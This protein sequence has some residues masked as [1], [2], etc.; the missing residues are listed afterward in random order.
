MW[1]TKEFSRLVN[2][3]VR[4]LHYYDKIDLLKPSIRE[5]NDYRLYSEDDL[6]KLQQIIALKF[7]GFELS[8]IKELLDNEQSIQQRFRAQADM[9]QQKAEAT[10]HAS[11]LLGRLVEEAEQNKSISWEQVLTMIEVFQMT[12][13][14]EHSWV[15]EIYNENELKQYAEF[16]TKLKSGKTAAEKKAFEENWYNLL[17]E[18]NQMLSTDPTSSAGKKMGEKFMQWVNDVYGKEYAHLRTKKFEKGFGEGK[19]LDDVGLTKE[20]VAWL[21]K[22][23]DAYWRDR[24]YRVLEQVGIIDDAILHKTW[25]QVMDDMYGNEASR[26]QELIETALAN[27]KVSKV[28]KDWLSKLL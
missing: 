23:M 22:A 4:T 6:L 16:E 5:E 2:V 20:S 25:Q 24:I 9:L 10:L 26:K 18:V 12:Q 17:N 11:Q 14:L 21:E 7:F 1:Y 15:K 3:S 27:P 13:N 28:A 19:G 8:Q